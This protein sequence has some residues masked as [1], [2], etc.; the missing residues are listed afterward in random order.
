MSD[1]LEGIR[2]VEVATFVAAPWAGAILADLGADVVHLE[3]AEQGDP[4]RGMSANY[5]I[6]PAPDKLTPDA[7]DVFWELENRNKR[8]LGIRLNHPKSRD[9]V[10]RLVQRAD[11][12]LSN[13][14]PPRKTALGLDYE[15]LSSLNPHLI[16]ASMTGYG[17]RGPLRERPAFDHTAFWAQTGLMHAL[18]EGRGELPWLRFGTGDHVA[19]AI[20][21]GAIG[22]ALYHRERTGRGQHIDLS[23]FH[24]GLV[25]M[26]GELELQWAYGSVPLRGSRQCP[27]NPLANYYQA[28]DGKWLLINMARSQDYWPILCQA[29]GHP[30]LRDDP[31]FA[32]AE[33]RGVNSAELV[34]FLDGLFGSRTSEAWGKTLDEYGIPWAPIQT[35][36]DVGQDPQLHA[37]EFCYHV[38][39]P[40]AGPLPVVK[41]PFLFSETPPTYRRPAPNLGQDTDAILQE[42]GYSADAI[43]AMRQEGAVR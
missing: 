19:G 7:F 37:N 17:S 28:S 35:A 42:L 4:L 22:M 5:G 34:Q 27:R 11:V 3:H 23:L 32:D 26:A 38:D 8:D 10:Q 6:T 43:V 25:A 9:V 13:L 15:T 40:T 30:E 33:A 39:H 21:A 20:L 18:V 2:V 36:A 41:P 12:F 31:R 16:Y 14:L 1:I 29:I 24:T